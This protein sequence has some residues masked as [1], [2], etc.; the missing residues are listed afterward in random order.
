MALILELSP[1]FHA[2]SP[3]LIQQTDVALTPLHVLPDYFCGGAGQ[4]RAG[5]VK[6]LGHD[7][8][9]GDD[10]SARD[11]SAFQNRHVAADPYVVTDEN[12]RALGSR[13]PVESFE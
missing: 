10:T 4:E 2:F 9:R 12:R 5:F 8:A 3:V 11:P 1:Q 6:G 7:C 13:W